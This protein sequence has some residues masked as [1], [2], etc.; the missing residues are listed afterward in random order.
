MN[1]PADISLYING[2]NVGGSPSGQSNSTMA[3][4]FS[5]DVGKI[6][7]F[8]SNGVTS[9]FKGSID[10]VR[11]WNRAL[12]LP[13]VQQAM[14]KKLSGTESGLVGYWNFNELNGPTVIDNSIGK[15]NGTIMGGRRVFSGAPI[16]DVS[17][18][19]YTAS[20]SGNSISLQDGDDQITVNNVQGNPE[21]IHIYEVKNQPSQT[22]GLPVG[23]ITQ[24]YFGAFASSLHTGNSFDA[25]YFFKGSQSCKTFS[26]SDNSVSTWTSSGNPV[27]NISQRTELIKALGQK[28]D[29]D[30][31]PDKTACNPSSVTLSTGI[32]DPQVSFLWNTGETTS[33]IN[34]NKSGTYSVAVAGAC[35]ITTDNVA[36]QFESSPPS[37]S[38]GIDKT[39]C[40]FAPILLDPLI[41]S[42]GYQF[43]WQDGST[44][45]VFQVKDFGKYWV[46]VKNNCGT[47]SD[48]V[49]YVRYKG[50]IGF[51]PNVITPNNG[52]ELNQYFKIDETLKGNVSLVVM[53]RWGKEV[54][55]SA[56]Y[57][58][59]WD[60][61]NLSP[62]V[63]Y[64]V[65][66]GPCI[67]EIRD[68]LTI[69]H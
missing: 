35:G 44:D 67:E 66:G 49:T 69:L 25:S 18:Y 8:L 27:T 68:W 52:D 19:T 6:G 28:I 15:Q 5:G 23:S 59:D 53:N 2:I 31:G 42:K 30:L 43:L 57:E 54:Y 34:V 41:N 11:L 56:A 36:V 4:S 1:S 55:R 3:S 58:N 10:E 46:N 38:L 60:G 20:W 61:D 29:F 48:T 26:R 62:G 37:I 40:D 13:E 14:C 22:G 51:L 47:V 7:Y 24:P 65:L 33:S 50:Q 39:F 45:S 17:K 63:Y 64:I 32:T 16:G 12:S 9:Y 21:G